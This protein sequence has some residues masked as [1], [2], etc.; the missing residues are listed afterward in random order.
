[1][2]IHW[3]QL[4]WITLMIASL[5]IALE[6]HGKPKGNWS[7]PYTLIAVAVEAVLL[8]FGGFFQRIH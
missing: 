5:V 3:P 7:F 2:I 4:C 8:W 1:M 6:N